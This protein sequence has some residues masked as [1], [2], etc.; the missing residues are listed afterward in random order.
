MDRTANPNPVKSAPTQLKY[1]RVEA[2][3]RQLAQTLP[4]GA[5][6]PAERDLAVTY[7]CNF[8][9]VRKALKQMVDD[10]T[11]IRRIGSGTFIARHSGENLPIGGEK[12][13]G[14]LVFQES[15]AYAYRILQSLAH[16][17]LEENLDLRSSWVRD[18]S[19]DAL[20]QAAQLKRDGCV[21]LTLPWFPHERTEEIR[22]FV[23]KCPLPVSLAMLI[24][25]LERNCFIEPSLFGSGSGIDGLCRY[26]HSLG[27]RRI[28]FL[29]PDSSNDVILQRRLTE[30]VRYTSRENMP[31]P[32]GL[33]PPGAKAMD[34]LAERW[35]AYRGDLAII[36]YD[37]EHALRFITAMHKIGLSA[38][39]DFR[40][41][42]CND[43][44]ASRY[45][46]PPLS[47]VH[48]YFDYISHWLLK[49]ALALSE[50]TVCQSTQPPRLQ[51][52]V[53]HTCGGRDMIDDS[54]R[55]RFEDL[56]I[57]LDQSFDAAPAKP[58]DDPALETS[59]AA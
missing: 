49:S 21:A 11:I 52:L 40:I 2:E 4:V 37:D 16:T 41:V 39:A 17:G 28:A 30:F 53:R 31:S 14:V 50:G 46:D 59:A 45:S 3:I 54:F 55:S 35:K 18:F 15:N 7:N 1:Q 5:K 20:L 22:T 34:Q 32:C 38:P 48:Q 44:E 57:V 25:G 26:Y 12:R 36:C 19:E 27:Q 23:E 6:L 33:V 13:I 29:G 42:G 47:T 58:M 8:L 10:G 51:M 9:T 43:T 56:D 24:P